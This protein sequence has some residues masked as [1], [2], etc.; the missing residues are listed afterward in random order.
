MNMVMFRENNIITSKLSN[1]HL[2]LIG[3]DGDK[4]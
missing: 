4:S 2:Q 3:N 1:K